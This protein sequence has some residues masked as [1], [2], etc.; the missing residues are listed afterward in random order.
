MGDYEFYTF[1]G[2]D[3]ATVQGYVVKPV[4]YEK[5]KKY[6]VAFIIHGG[7]QGAMTNEFHYRWNPQ[8]YAGAGL[9]RGHRE[10]PWLD[11]LRPGVHRCDFRRLGRQAARGSAERLGGGAGKV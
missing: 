8:T 5:G 6:P 1:K 3:N 10:F 4:G 7:P 2:A 9:R 11:R